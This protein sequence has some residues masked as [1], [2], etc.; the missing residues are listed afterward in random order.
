MPEKPMIILIVMSTVIIVGL[1]AMMLAEPRRRPQF[2]IWSDET[3]RRLLR[4]RK[5][6][7]GW[8]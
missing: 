1:A 3:E 7:S 2:S 4:E 8:W 5:I 6:D